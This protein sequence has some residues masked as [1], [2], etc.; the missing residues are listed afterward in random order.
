MFMGCQP[1]LIDLCGTWMNCPGGLLNK[2]TRKATICRRPGKIGQRSVSAAGLR[3][4]FGQ[5]FAA[6]YSLS[7]PIDSPHMRS[8]HILTVKTHCF[9]AR[10]ES[11][12]TTAR[13]VS[14]RVNLGGNTRSAAEPIE[15]R[16][17]VRDGP[18]HSYASA[19]FRLSIASSISAVFL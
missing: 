3:V 7:S 12:R 6:L 19:R 1:I 16:S 5:S 11:W 8:R 9:S 18:P 13:M 2:M 4:S 10:M 17:A 14:A 15:N